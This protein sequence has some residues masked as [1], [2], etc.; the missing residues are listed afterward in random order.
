MLDG[1]GGRGVGGTSFGAKRWRD[2]WVGGWLWVGVG[3]GG[4]TIM[5]RDELSGNENGD[6]VCR[7]RLC[8]W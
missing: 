8:M 1:L 6:G 4:W 2:G 7:G 3:R 5:G